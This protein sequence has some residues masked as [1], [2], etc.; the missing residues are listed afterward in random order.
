MSIAFSRVLGITAALVVLVAAAVAVE[1]RGD[2]APPD[3]PGQ[4][5]ET[6]QAPAAEA[7]GGAPAALSPSPPRDRNHPGAEPGPPVEALVSAPAPS[8]RASIAMSMRARHAT[9]ADRRRAMLAALESSGRAEPAR[10]A[11]TAARIEQWHGALDPAIMGAIERG[12][13]RC[14]RAGCAVELWFATEPAYEAAREHVRRLP[15]ETADGGRLVTP[16]VAVDDGA[17]VADWISLNAEVAP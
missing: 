1:R 14:F 3:R 17:F 2:N 5:R 4:R 6:A 13:A 8:A 16:A 15:A 7:R 11:E 10:A 9:G 12:P